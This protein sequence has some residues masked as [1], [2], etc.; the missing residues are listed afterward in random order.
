MTSAAMNLRVSRIPRFYRNAR[1]R[2]SCANPRAPVTGFGG[3]PW[4]AS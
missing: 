3:L 4:P 2:T 1:P